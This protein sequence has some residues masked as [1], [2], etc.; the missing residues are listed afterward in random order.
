VFGTERAAAPQD[1]ED[2]PLVREG[3]DRR[4]RDDVRAAMA[5]A[6]VAIY[7]GGRLSESTLP[8]DQQQQLLTLPRQS[9]AHVDA[10]R[11][12]LASLPDGGRRA[13]AFVPL[14]GEGWDGAVLAVAVADPGRAAAVTTAG[15]TGLVLCLLSSPLLLVLLSELLAVVANLRLRLLAVL[16][17][18]SLAPLAVLSFVLA[19]VLERGHESDQ[20]EGMRRQVQSAIGQLEDQMQLLHGS[21]NRWLSDL[22]ALLAEKLGGH[23]AGLLAV[24]A[25][26]HG[27]PAAARVARRLPETR[28]EPAA[29]RRPG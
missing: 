27:G 20:Q 10:E 12:M 22:G 21:A 3:Q 23:G 16:S 5:A 15:R 13:S 8:V 7:R 4:L 11:P 29:A 26:A 1:P 9:V 24:A 18:A 2:S 19:Q 25:A 14:N 6:E 17:I 28:M